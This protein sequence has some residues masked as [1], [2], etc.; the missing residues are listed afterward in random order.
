MINFGP[1]NAVADAEVELEQLVMKD[2]HKAA[3]FFVDF[4]R[5]ASVLGYNN[6]ALLRKAYLA[7]PRRIKDEMVHFDKP[8]EMDHLRD[9][10]LKIDQHYWEQCSKIAREQASQ[11]KPKVQKDNP[12]KPTDR[13]ATLPA[14]NANAKSTDQSKGKSMP[15]SGKKP[16]A[17]EKLG[18]DGKLT[19]EERKQRFEQDLCLV[20]GSASHK[21]C[22]CPKSTKAR[23]ATLSDESSDSQSDNDPDMKPFEAKN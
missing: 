18:K 3:K 15:E 20:C 6:Q 21:V 16:D 8:R 13:K 22:D 4:Y 12:P 2:N 10:V 23:G 17:P 14:P 19:E 5:I 7:L 11:P 9:L 1:Y